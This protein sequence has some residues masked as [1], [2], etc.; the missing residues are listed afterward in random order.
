MK[1]RLFGGESCPICKI[2]LT[3]LEC[4]KEYISCEYIDAFADETQNICDEN[5]VDELPHIQIFDDHD[6]EKIIK[7]FKGIDVL[8]ILRD[9]CD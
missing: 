5:D 9:I 1:V 2:A 3:K 8:K 7:E 4:E 6:S